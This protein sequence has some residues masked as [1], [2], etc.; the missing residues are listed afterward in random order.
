MARYLLLC[1]T[2]ISLTACGVK[3]PPIAPQR[4]PEPAKLELDCS[5]KDPDCDKQDPNYRP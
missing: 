4:P 1:L 3:A 2:L 5:P